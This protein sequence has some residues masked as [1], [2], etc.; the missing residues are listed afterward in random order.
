MKTAEE[1]QVALALHSEGQRDACCGLPEWALNGPREERGANP[2]C[3][4]PEWD[5]GD[6]AAAHAVGRATRVALKRDRRLYA[7]GHVGDSVYVLKAGVVKHV[8]TA[9]DGTNAVVRLVTAG[10]VSG[11]EAIAGLPYRHNAIVLHPGSACRIPV[12]VIKQ[13]ERID[14]EAAKQLCQAWQQAAVDSERLLRM[15]HGP[16]LF[17]VASLLQ[18]LGEVIPVGDLIRI[19][20]ADIA[21]FFGLTEVSVARAMLELRNRGLI[22]QRGNSIS[23]IDSRIAALAGKAFLLDDARRISIDTDRVSTDLS[24]L[25]PVKSIPASGNETELTVGECADGSSCT[26]LTG[27]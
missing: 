11:L 2:L 9:N 14:P 16:A 21:E 18:F 15:A 24:I 10:G 22:V 19:R 3:A 4:L 8:A 27:Q 20:H 5:V 25:T 12:D 17:R 26:D 23:R 6:S 13:Y 1:V 7:A